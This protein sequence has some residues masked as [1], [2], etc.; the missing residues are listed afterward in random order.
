MKKFTKLFLTCAAVTAVTAA[1]ATT[2]MAAVDVTGGELTGTYA[3]GQLSLT[4][5]TEKAETVLVLKA[6]ADVKA[7][8]D[9]DILYVNQDEFT[10]IK[11]LGAPSEEDVQGAIVLVGYYDEN[12]KFGILSGKI[13]GSNEEVLVGDADGSDD[14]T[15]KDATG[16]LKYASSSGQDGIEAEYVERAAYSNGDYDVTTKDATFVLKC[17]SNNGPTGVDGEYAGV[18]MVIPAKPA[19]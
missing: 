7:V 1:V 17:A 18:R 11:L 10:T 16:I 19:E 14:I 3:D 4:G 5:L 15:T 2:A 12:D 9:E 13:G 6:D 8:K